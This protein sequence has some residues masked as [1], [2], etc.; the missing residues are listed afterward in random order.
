MLGYETE[1]RL[2]NFLVAIA[3]GENVLEKARQ[4]LCEIREFSPHA[5]FQR[6]DR[7]ANDSITSFEIV[8]FLRDN[9]VLNASEA[10]CYRLLKF[11]DSDEDGRLSFNE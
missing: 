3:D 8:N 11:F 7:D 2:K 6:F 1:R 9:G 4:R 10:E 5:A